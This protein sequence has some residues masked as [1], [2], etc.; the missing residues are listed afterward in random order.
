MG[1]AKHLDVR[2]FQNNIIYEI[3]DLVRDNMADMLE[4]RWL[5]KDPGG[6][7]L[8]R[9]QGE[10]G[11]TVAG[12]MVMEGAIVRNKGARL[13][14]NGEVWRRAKSIPSSVSRTMSRR[15]RQASNVEYDLIPSTAMKKAIL[16]A[17]E[18]ENSSFPLGLQ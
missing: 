6:R 1:E 14:R 16:E 18:V 8:S 12:S 17:F 5:K 13:I 2:V 11:R 3:I 4:P 9:F 15:S 7:R 10:Q